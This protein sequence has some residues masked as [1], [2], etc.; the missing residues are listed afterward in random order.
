MRFHVCLPTPLRPCWCQLCSSHTLLYIEY[1][2][3]PLEHTQR[4]AARPISHPLSSCPLQSVSFL[5]HRS[6]STLTS[7]MHSSTTCSFEL[8]IV[9]AALVPPISRWCYCRTWRC[10]SPCRRP[11][12]WISFSSSS[13]SSPLLDISGASVWLSCCC[14]SS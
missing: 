14:F 5:P 13:T 7:G 2:V 11:S 4:K 6:T 8:R 10:F 9:A 3:F 1:C 12:S